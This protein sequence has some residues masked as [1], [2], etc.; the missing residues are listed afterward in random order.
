MTSENEAK[1]RRSKLTHDINQ[2]VQ[3]IELYAS[4]LERRISDAEARELL[5]KIREAVAQIRTRLSEYES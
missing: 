3:A 1:S 2:P 5:G 4:V